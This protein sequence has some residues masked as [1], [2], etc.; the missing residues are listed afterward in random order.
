MGNILITGASGF[1]GSFIVR[2]ALREGFSVW[3][4]VRKSSPRDYL[5]DSRINFI[6]LDLGNEGRLREQLSGHRFDFVVHAAGATKSATADGFFRVNTSGTVNLVNA[7]RAT[8]MPLRRFVFISSLSVFGPAREEWPYQEIKDTDT[9]R[10]DTLY[11][12]SKAKAEDFLSTQTDFPWITLRLTG[13]YGPREKDYLQMFKSI[14]SHVDFAVGRR[15][16]AI[17]FVHV[18][19]VV[20]AVFR[21]LEHGTEHR[22]YFISDG[23]T[24]SSRQFSDL[25]RRALGNP[26]LLRITAPLWLL[27][28]VTAAGQFIGRLTGHMPVLN[29]DKYHILSQRNWRCDITPAINE[30]GFRPSVT[31]EQG[32]SSTLAW[33][34]DNGW[35]KPFSPLFKRRSKH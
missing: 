17:T 21:A 25:I 13:V 34:I 9:R 22:A 5:R 23:Q 30:L 14:R 2:E 1:I 18:D 15:P 31:L 12:Q 4:A 8:G 29:S 7:L 35:V 3:A 33:Y 19:D 6:E 27:R 10:P 24:Y 28:T 26:W 20:Q 11:G 16:Q 32:V